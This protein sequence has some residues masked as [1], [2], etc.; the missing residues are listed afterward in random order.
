MTSISKIKCYGFYIQANRLDYEYKR[1]LQKLKEYGMSATGNKDVDRARLKNKELEKVKDANYINPE[2]LTVSVEEQVKIQG[3]KKKDL[4][5]DIEQKETN[6]L[7]QQLL[8]EQLM[9][10]INMKNKKDLV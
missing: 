6:K 8:G 7:G 2:L 9:I 10:A 3:E 4:N 1:I 5:T